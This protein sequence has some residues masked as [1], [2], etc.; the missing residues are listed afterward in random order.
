[1]KHFFDSDLCAFNARRVSADA[2]IVDEF[3]PVAA[4]PEGSGL[5]AVT[6]G[7]NSDIQWLSATTPERFALFEDA[8][9]RLGVPELVSDVID[10]DRQ[11]RL[12][13]GSLVVRSR[14]AEPYFHC[15]WRKSNN[16]AFTFLTPV[17]GAHEQFGLLYYD[18]QGAVRHYP[19]RRGEG[20]LFGD[21][22]SH[23]TAP[24]QSDGPVALLCFEFG[25]DRMADWPEV[26]HQMKGRARLLR[27]ADGEF[28]TTEA[29]LAP[30]HY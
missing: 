9:R 14:C 11:V 21:W 7:W 24:G 12:Y 18:A 23:A 2:A 6:P 25:S 10:V 22:F 13:C 5:D 17:S 20:I 15:D 28:V 16:Q 8:F 4:D 29:G 30:H 1:M 19:Y 27:R 26:Y 3:L